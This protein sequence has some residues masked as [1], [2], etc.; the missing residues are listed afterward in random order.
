VEKTYRRREI[1]TLLL[2][3]LKDSIAEAVPKVRIINVQ[4]SDSGMIAFLEH[5]G[6]HYTFNQ[7]EMEMA[8]EGS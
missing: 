3:T 4:H 1:A 2:A 6:F 7:Y 5:V 8:L